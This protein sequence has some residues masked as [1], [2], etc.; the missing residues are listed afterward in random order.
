MDEKGAEAVGDV[1]WAKLNIDEHV[2]HGSHE[3]NNHDGG[4]DPNNGDDQHKRE[5]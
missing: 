2:I 5:V 4:S 3:I 1:S